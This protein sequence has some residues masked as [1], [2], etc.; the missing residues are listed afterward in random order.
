MVQLSITVTCCT[1]S[2]CKLSPE[3]APEH[4]AWLEGFARW[5]VHF[6]VLVLKDGYFTNKNGAIINAGNMGYD[7]I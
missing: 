3:T 6:K 1:G 4:R 5:D 7:M 2:A